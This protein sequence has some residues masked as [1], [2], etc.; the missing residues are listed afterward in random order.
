MKNYEKKDCYQMKQNCLLILPLSDHGNY[1][2]SSY[3]YNNAY[4]VNAEEDLFNPH[5][6]FDQKFSSQ[7]EVSPMVLP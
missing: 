1:Q 6:S 4:T 5:I 2:F 7:L 3:S